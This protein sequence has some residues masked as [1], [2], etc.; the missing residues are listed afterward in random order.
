MDPSQCQGREEAG[1]RHG[2]RANGIKH[3]DRGMPA[4][5]RLLWQA[6]QN[7]AMVHRPIGL[8]ITMGIRL[9]CIARVHT[10]CVWL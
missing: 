7:A 9:S 10:P 6:V 2:C 3:E 8:P 1:T 5:G 4:V